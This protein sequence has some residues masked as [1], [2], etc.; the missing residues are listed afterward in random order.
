MSNFVI[1]IK[2]PEL[3]GA[4]EKLAA[5]L[6]AKSAANLSASGCC[7]ASAQPVTIPAQGNTPV[8]AP[9]PQPPQPPMATPMQTPTAPAPVPQP[10][11][12]PAAPAP[13][14]T[15]DALARAAAD[16]MPGKMTEL[17]T[18]LAQYGV[19]RLDRLPAEH[20]GSF[21]TAIRGMGAKI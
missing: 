16:L 20:Y 19:D 1:E 9:M 14:Y 3:A 8:V 4:M 10:V 21:A 13:T 18:L 7:P 17:T 12:A 11:A 6:M 5:A 15:L 2:A